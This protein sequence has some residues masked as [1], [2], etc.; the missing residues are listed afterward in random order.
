MEVTPNVFIGKSLAIQRVREQIRRFA[1]V[2]TPLVFIG[3]TGTGKERAARL[4][5]GLSGRLG[6]F[7]V[8]DAHCA[9]DLFAVLLRGHGQGSFTGAVNAR[10][11]AFE[12]AHRGSLFLDSVD[13]LSLE[14]QKIL[15]GILS[16]ARLRRIGESKSRA[17]D[18]RLLASSQRDLTELV[19]SG[20]FRSDLYHR[21]MVLKIDLPP[22]RK[23]PLDLVL[24]LELLLGSKKLSAEAFDAFIRWP[25]KG[26][27]R[28]LKH[29]IKASLSLMDEKILKGSVARQ[30]LSCQQ[31]QGAVDVASSYRTLKTRFL[32]QER[33]FLTSLL[34]QHRGSISKAARALG[35]HRQQ[36]SRRLNRLDQS[37]AAESFF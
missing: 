1:R 37:L 30:L 19:R 18:V 32:K 17:V 12:W 15:L 14:A 25:W 33:D 35:I 10:S 26:N 13:S 16:Q 21:L 7:V 5:H 3:E 34:N 23:R 11:G 2:S 29:V 27:V 9:D 4:V 6:A 31:Q 24:W 20:Q 36:L 8:V 28:E 22:L